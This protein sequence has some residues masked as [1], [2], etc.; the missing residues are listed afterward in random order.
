MFLLLLTLL[1]VS[2]CSHSRAAP[3]VEE[4][5]LQLQCGMTLGE[6]SAKSPITPEHLKQED[7]RDVYLVQ[8][9]SF[10]NRTDLLLYFHDS[11]LEAT[12]IGL[13]VPLSTEIEYDE[14]KNLCGT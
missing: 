4:L 5:R 13:G 11:G 12:R 2:G 9:S 3:W 1:Y 7:G 6:V 10:S 14:I 8:S